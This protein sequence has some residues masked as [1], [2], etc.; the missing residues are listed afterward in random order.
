MEKLATGKTL[1][2]S[3]SLLIHVW[4]WEI[5][6]LSIGAEDKV[7]A[8]PKSSSKK[9]QKQV[10]GQ[11]GVVEDINPDL[12]CDTESEYLYCLSHDVQV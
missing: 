10:A 3:K 5:T 8:K 9:E 12:E 11:I 2:I 4:S 7:T 6:Y 1:C